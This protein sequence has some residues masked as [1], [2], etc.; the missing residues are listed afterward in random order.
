V[1]RSATLLAHPELRDAM[2]R[3]GGRINEATMRMLNEAVDIKRRD[4]AQVVRE[5]LERH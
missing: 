5:F 4:P 2:H 3:L 1:I